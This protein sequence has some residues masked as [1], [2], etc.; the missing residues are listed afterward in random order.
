MAEERGEEQ[1]TAGPAAPCGGVAALRGHAAKD[2]SFLPQSPSFVAAEGCAA[3]MHFIKRGNIAAFFAAAQQT[4]KAS[5][6]TAPPFLTSSAGVATSGNVSH[7]A[8]AAAASPAP[9][10]LC[11][12]ALCETHERTAADAAS[13]TP[14]HSARAAATP[15]LGTAAAAAAPVKAPGGAAG[16]SPLKVLRRAVRRGKPLLLLQCAASSALDAMQRQEVSPREAAQVLQ[17]LSRHHELLPRHVWRDAAAAL[18]PLLKKQRQ[19]VDAPLLLSSQS[20]RKQHDP[21]KPRAPSQRQQQLTLGDIVTIFNAFARVNHRPSLLLQEALRLISPQDAAE[22][23][24]QQKKADY[25]RHSRLGRAAFAEHS[26]GSVPQEQQALQQHAQESQRRR[27]GADTPAATTPTSNPQAAASEIPAPVNLV[28]AEGEC[29]SMLQPSPAATRSTDRDLLL[30]LHAVAKLQLSAPSLLRQLRQWLLQ[31]SER[32]RPLQLAVALHALAAAKHADAEV[33]RTVGDVLLQQTQ[34]TEYRQQHG[35]LRLHALDA[36]GISMLLLAQ[37]R[38]KTADSRLCR[39]LLQHLLSN[40]S[41][42]PSRKRSELLNTSSTRDFDTAPASAESR[43]PSTT[44]RRRDYQLDDHHQDPNTNDVSLQLQ[45]FRGKELAILLLY[46]SRYHRFHPP[47]MVKSIAEESLLLL[48]SLRDRALLLSAHALAL[49]LPQLQRQQKEQQGQL[50]EQEDSAAGELLRRQQDRVASIVAARFAARPPGGHLAFALLHVLQLLLGGLRQQE[51]PS[52]CLD[53]LQSLQQLLARSLQSLTDAQLARTAAAAAA[54][55]CMD[56]SL[57]DRLLTEGACRLHDF[58]PKHAKM[59]LAALQQQQPW[60]AEGSDLHCEGEEG[61]IH[62]LGESKL[63]Q[64]H[65][66]GSAEVLQALAAR[67]SES[68]HQASPP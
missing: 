13:A 14:Q 52:C 63:L 9:P 67:A 22:T 7:L 19:L 4:A 65:I 51:F 57:R 39:P 38:M 47:A 36:G 62:Y 16:E 28:G 68:T 11:R 58:H 42:K 17:V 46:L 5:T 49:L 43:T 18:L 60:E 2:V 61:S 21:E 35:L 34:Q 45:H 32:L 24:Q 3:S 40:E 30:L 50:S 6:S 31:S 66:E 8:G 41:R 10:P 53:L 27:E 54:L 55:G 25:K 29:R 64:R 20:Y 15:A 23:Q 56:S 12:R 1:Q 48:P 33:L 26:A 59:L 44:T 37:L